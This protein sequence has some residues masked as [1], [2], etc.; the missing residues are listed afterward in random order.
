MSYEDEQDEAPKGFASKWLATIVL[1][2]TISSFVGIAW[3]ASNSGSSA[4]KDDDLLVVEADKSPIKEKPVD[5]GGMQF[6][7]QDK[8]V[9]ETF[10]SSPPQAAKV[11]RVLPSPEE[12][13]KAE[14]NSVAASAVVSEDGKPAEQVENKTPDKVTEK[15]IEVQRIEAVG[16]DDKK[17]AAKIAEAPKTTVEKTVTKVTDKPKPIATAS[18]GSAKIQ[19]GAYPSDAEARKDWARIQKKFP[20]LAHK[21]PQIVKATVNGKEFYRLRVGGFASAKEAKS[22]CATLSA[23]GQGCILPTN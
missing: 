2:A 10:A 23:K 13:I 18:G 11:E 17:P 4:V 5:A 21:S 15:P 19:L 22:V 1:I 16:V 7:N 6:P 8:T 3:Y 14:D 9:F 12:P 20:D